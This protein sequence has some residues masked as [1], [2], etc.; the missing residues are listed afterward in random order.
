MQVYFHS[1]LLSY[2]PR[3]P[4]I[5]TVCACVRVCVR[6]C[7][8]VCV[9]V[10]MRACV[11]VCVCIHTRVES[12][13]IWCFFISYGLS[14]GTVFAQH[15]GCSV[16]ISS[17]LLKNAITIVVRNVRMSSDKIIHDL[18]PSS[19]IDCRK[20]NSLAALCWRFS[21]LVFLLILSCRSL[22]NYLQHFSKSSHLYFYSTSYSADCFKAALWW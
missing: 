8:C 11:C 6:V 9:C 13:F 19:T 3:V 12:D 4:T 21:S 2:I 10:C 17:C 7:V 22:F 14:V 20:Q 1:L 18:L 15:F 5:L 16:G